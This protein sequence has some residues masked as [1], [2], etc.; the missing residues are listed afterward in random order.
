MCPILLGT[1]EDHR[2]VCPFLLGVQGVCGA[3]CPGCVF[4]QG[5]I[6]HQHLVLSHLLDPEAGAFL[7]P[8]SLLIVSRS[9]SHSWSW[10]KPLVI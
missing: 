1:Q 7:R 10:Q 6:S 3:V 5:H 8:S 4:C 2:C 9:Q